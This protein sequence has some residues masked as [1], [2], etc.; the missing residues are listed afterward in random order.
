[1]NGPET[2]R[3]R[4]KFR[5]NAKNRAK[6][7]QEINPFNE[8]NEDYSLETINCTE[9]QKFISYCGIQDVAFFVRFYAKHP[10]RNC[11]VANVDGQ[12]GCIEECIVKV[13]PES[14]YPRG[15]PGLSNPV[16]DSFRH[17]FEKDGYWHLVM[18]EY[19]IDTNQ[20]GEWKTAREY[21]NAFPRVCGIADPLRTDIVYG[22]DAKRDCDDDGFRKDNLYRRSRRLRRAP[23]FGSGAS[24]S[25]GGGPSGG[26]GTA[27]SSI[28]ERNKAKIK[29]DRVQHMKSF[30]EGLERRKS[31][32]KR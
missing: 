26:G 12:G 1:M 21:D 13:F 14:S 20:L 3:I 31:L 7:Y 29:K 24:L 22:P 16:D 10:T 4:Q 30:R 8:G 5:I 32:R 2:Q 6:I 23:P 9:V 18:R 11:V 28:S 25:G 17:I 19:F 27:D 15:H